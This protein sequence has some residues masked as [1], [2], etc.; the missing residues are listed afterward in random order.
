M[1]PGPAEDAR[2]ITLVSTFG[3]AYVASGSAPAGVTQS[4]FGLWNIPL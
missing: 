2:Q 4:T 3:N 1:R